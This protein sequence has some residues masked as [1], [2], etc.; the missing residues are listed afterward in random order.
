[1]YQHQHH[2][3]Y[4][5]AH[6]SRSLS[7]SSSL[8]AAALSSPS[9]YTRTHSVTNDTFLSFFSFFSDSDP[10]HGFVD[11]VTKDDAVS[12][13]LLQLTDNQILMAADRTNDTSTGRRS[14][15]VQSNP[16]FSGK[17]ARNPSLFAGPPVINQP[18]CRIKRKFL[19]SLPTWL[20]PVTHARSPTTT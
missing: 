13:G 11:Y 10:T 4:V 14:I 15:R 6:S 12:S 8:A 5:R 1:M 16:T 17:Y 9:A 19:N 2:H 18:V 7:S 3:E 20:T